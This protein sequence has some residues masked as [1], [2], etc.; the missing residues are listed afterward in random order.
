MLRR[1]R[2]SAKIAG[3]LQRLLFFEACGCAMYPTHATRGNR[4][5]RYYVCTAAQKKGWNR[6]PSK[7]IPAVE[8]EQFVI[9][10]IRDI[11]RDPD[12]VAETIRQTQS[13]SAE[14]LV[15]LTDSC[16]RAPEESVNRNGQ[17][18]IR[19]G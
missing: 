9:E 16:V 19:A 18:A 5:Y 11:G 2:V 3:P 13:Q 8:I 1:E 7:S 6:C 15:T 17:I 14:R 12:L 4:R 10:Q